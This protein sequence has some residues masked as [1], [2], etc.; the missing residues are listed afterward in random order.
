MDF[1]Y[2]KSSVYMYCIYNFYVICCVF[3]CV[4][5][6]FYVFS[7]SM[8]CFSAT[9]DQTFIAKAHGKFV[10]CEISQYG[11]LLCSCALFTTYFG[12]TLLK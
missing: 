2:K 4:F 6:G 3:Y 12:Q 10:P 1:I 8:L 9:F 7:N 5:E 11:F